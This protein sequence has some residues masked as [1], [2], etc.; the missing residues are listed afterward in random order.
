MI[1]PHSIADQQDGAED[2]TH[3]PLRAADHR[4]RQAKPKSRSGRNLTDAERAAN[5][6][7][8]ITLRLPAETIMLIGILADDAGLTRAQYVHDLVEAADLAHARRAASG[9]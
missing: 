2:D 5:G 7:G 3:N 9:S 8:R 6:Y 1:D 4:M